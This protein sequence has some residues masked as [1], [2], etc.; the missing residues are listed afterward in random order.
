VR[1]LVI[2]ALGMPVSVLV[3]YECLRVAQN[4]F[5]H[6]NLR[7]PEAAERYLRLV[8]VTPDFHRIHHSSQRD[9]TDSNFSTVVPWFDYLF[10]SYRDRP[11]E[12]HCRME[13][14]LE[15][16]RETKDSRLDRLLSM[17]LRVRSGQLNL[18]GPASV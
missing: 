8:V 16:F 6:S 17:P 15:Q 10:G 13:L 5:S 9:Y 3:A 14:G 18:P 2:A 12:A 7:L 11:F 1:M 4:L